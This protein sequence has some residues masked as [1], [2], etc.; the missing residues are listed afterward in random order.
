M[1]ILIQL[2]HLSD[3]ASENTKNGTKEA[4]HHCTCRVTFAVHGRNRSG[5][6]HQ[7]LIKE[8]CIAMTTNQE[9]TFF[10]DETIRRLKKKIKSLS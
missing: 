5:K 3:I 9:K 1:L 8:N 6:Q 7:D 2:I 4:I 10:A